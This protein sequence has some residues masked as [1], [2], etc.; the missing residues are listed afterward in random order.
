MINAENLAAAVG[1]QFP[2]A[3]AW[4]PQ[5]ESTFDRFSILD[6]KEQAMF[7]AQCAHESSGFKHL[8]ENLNYSPAALMATFHLHFRDLA[9]AEQYAR[10]PEKIANRVYANRM[11]N[12]DEASGDGWRYRGRG[13]IQ[14]T[15][16]WSYRAFG[17]SI[18]M[19]MDSNPERLVIP[20]YAAMSAGYF[21]SANGCAGPARR[22]D[23]PVVTRII[24]GG[25]N[26][27]ADRMQ[28]YNKA[29]EALSL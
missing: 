7:L 6:I 1:L 26:G 24:N 29:L 12:G 5:I 16:R 19:D 10:R 28:R 20:R 22:G 17:N 9:E 18:H 23:V 15:G 21:W 14:I 4:L 2:V 11:G 13:L 3:L 8:D 25:S 27:L